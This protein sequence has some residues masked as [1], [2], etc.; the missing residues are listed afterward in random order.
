MLNDRI[1]RY[2]HARS[3]DTEERFAHF[4]QATFH[5]RKPLYFDEV[6]NANVWSFYLVDRDLHHTFEEFVLAKGLPPYAVWS[7]PDRESASDEIGRATFPIS[8]NGAVY[9]RP[10]PRAGQAVDY[11]LEVLEL[12]SNSAVL[13]FLGFLVD[14]NGSRSLQPSVAAVWLR[15]FV[16]YTG[17]R[18]D[19][20]V[21]PDS[22][23]E[24]LEGS[25][26]EKGV[27]SS[28]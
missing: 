21:I 13:G 4:W 23:R 12:N 14:F 25:L 26:A 1:H 5:R 24:A 20:A 11:T 6:E 28:S 3:F 27:W 7:R 2:Y 16:R 9:R 19:I 22:F 8:E 10:V 15:V 18:R 17:D